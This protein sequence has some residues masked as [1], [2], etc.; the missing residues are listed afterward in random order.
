MAQQQEQKLLKHSEEPQ[1]IAW[2]TG[3]WRRLPWAG[4]LALIAT[5]VA[6]AF[7]IQILVTSDGQPIDSWTYQ[8]TV[9]LSITYTLA[10]L[11]LQYALTQAITVAWWVKALRGD[12]K[13]RDLHHIWAFGHGV[14][15]IMFAGRSFNMIALTALVVTLVPIN[16][17]LLQRASVIES[18]TGAIARNLTL[19][20]NNETFSDTTGLITGRFQEANSLDVR[21]TQNVKAHN[22]RDP[23][24]MTDAGCIGT[25][26]GVIAG[27]GYKIDCAN[28]TYTPYNLTLDPVHAEAMTFSL[29]FSYWEWE[30]AL[31][32]INYTSAIKTGDE[33]EGFLTRTNCTL[34]PAT[35][36][37]PF[38]ISNNTISLDP[39]KSWKTDRATAFHVKHFIPQGPGVKGTLHGGFWLYLNTLYSSSSFTRHE[40]VYQWGSMNTGTTA[41]RYVDNIGGGCS[42]N[43]TDPTFD[44]MSDA[45]E[46]AFRAALYADH[47]P[48]TTFQ[49]EVQ[50][51]WAKIIYRSHYIYLAFAVAITLIAT[52]CVFSISLGWWHLGREVSLSPIEV[53]KAF[54][55]PVLQN[56]SSN[57][58]VE[59]L[60][61]EI[62]S[63]RVRYGATWNDENDIEETQPNLRFEEPG[64]CEKPQNGQ[65]FG[66]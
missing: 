33:C 57:A 8:P 44:I 11:A 30:T 54:A 42:G 35:I 59:A 16:G 64:E 43:F 41:M 10:N 36:E 66:H 49:V 46:L 1:P 61:K 37:Y 26:K 20:I 23:I 17:P 15:D 58:E 48:E 9:L 32:I 18:R 7:M 55:A 50:Q 24:K 56:A 21:F 38:I 31:T 60:V 12:A 22:N 13:V 5:L 29:N 47:I 52:L 14:K 34:T 25:C 19:N 3:F 2:K 63:R 45:R 27:A 28:D 65:V 4:H 53:A 51:E 6:S 39:E 62:G 40:G